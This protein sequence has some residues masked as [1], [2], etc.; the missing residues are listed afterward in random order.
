MW[1][2]RLMCCCGHQIKAVDGV[3]RINCQQRVKPLRAVSN[4]AG[5]WKAPSS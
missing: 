1:I 4:V 3:A 2:V 5:S